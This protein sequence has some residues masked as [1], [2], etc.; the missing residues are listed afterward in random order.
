MKFKVNYTIFFLWLMGL[1]NA[2]TDAHLSQ[3]N[4]S[5]LYLNPA[6]TGDIDGTFRAG[7][8]YR[9]QW[10]SV[11]IPF[12]TTILQTD[13]KINPKFLNK[14]PL[15]IGLKFLNDRIEIGNGNGS[16]SVNNLTASIA[17]PIKLGKN[18]I[19]Q[20]G[21]Y[22]A[23][24]Q[25]NLNLVNLN[26]ESNFNYLNLQFSNG[27]SILGN[28]NK[29]LIDFGIGSQYQQ[30]VNQKLS[31]KSGIAIFH[32]FNPDNSLFPS[33]TQKLHQK[34][35]FHTHAIYQTN[36][37][38]QLLPTLFYAQQGNASSVIIGNEILYPLGR[39]VVE[40]IDLRLGVYYRFNDAMI[41][42]FG[43]NHDN[44]SFIFSYDF[45]SSFLGEFN[46]R[47]GGFEF[48]IRYTNRMF[49]GGKDFKYILPGNRLL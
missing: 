32:L 47:R 16:W 19:L 20:N 22:F 44:F 24:Q 42:S 40:K 34:W 10:N 46:N 28:Y 33:S 12:E 21:I 31:F 4:E 14:I 15:G 7:I 45:T 1:V 18:K 39:R 8:N 29:N 41:Y 5:P 48:S 26:L 38:I 49:K 43:M 3:I 27:N 11:D 17:L 35:H 6:Q 13:F 25:Q 2:Q 36:K 23:F 9:N 30:T 37:N